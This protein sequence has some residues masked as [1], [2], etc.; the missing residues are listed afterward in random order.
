MSRLDDLEEELELWYQNYDAI[1]REAGDE[2]QSA[3][4]CDADE[5]AEKLLDELR[6]KLGPIEKRIKAL[7]K[8][9]DEEKKRV[10]APKVHGFS[11]QRYPKEERVCSRCGDPL[12]STQTLCYRC[13][14]LNR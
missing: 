11:P 1:E 12:G 6:E 7:E 14:T 4:N 3:Y 8:E 9:I 10:A 5:L 13:L 2:I